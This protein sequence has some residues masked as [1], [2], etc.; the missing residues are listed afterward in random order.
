MHREKTEDICKMK[1]NNINRQ[2]SH[3]DILKQQIYI[4]IYG[5]NTPLGKAFD[6]ALLFAIL[7]S[8]SAI[9]LES[10][11]GVDVLYHKQ[12]MILEWIF[13]IFFTLEYVLRIFCSKHPWRYIFSFYG[14]IDL[15]SILPMFVSFFV[16]GSNV[17]SSFRILR[18]LR[19]FRV[20]RMKKFVKESK[21]LKA[22]FIGSKTKVMVFLYAVFII[23]IMIGTLM[24]Y[25]EG[26]EN[27]FSNIPESVY[28]TIVTLTTV[29]YGDITPN[30]PMGKILSM[31]LMI[32]GFGIITI[33]MGIV[34]VEF[35]KQTKDIDREKKR[36][37]H[38]LSDEDLEE[39]LPVCNHCT[40]TDH[41]PDAKYCYQCGH[42]LDL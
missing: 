26:R 35:A 34:S 3:L 5:V 24:Y 25:V 19:L 7:L 41:F 36:A 17:L 28:Y 20:F 14:I 33:P 27:G 2:K 11:E 31:L 23:A 29:G 15:L 30:T 8:V 13:T 37:K 10:I 38:H 9:M 1:S 40:E 18:M 12:L 32:I 6:I 4:V 21:R 42:K 22:A 16:V 39:D